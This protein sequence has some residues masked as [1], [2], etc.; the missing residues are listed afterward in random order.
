MKTMMIA[1][2]PWWA[3]RILKGE[4]TV[5]LRKILPSR[6][7]N[8]RWPFKVLLYCTKGGGKF[9]EWEQKVIGEVTCKEI[10]T[11]YGFVK[12]TERTYGINRQLLK[13]SCVSQDALLKYADGRP[14]YGMILEQP[15]EYQRKRELEEYGVKWP[16][17]SYIYVEDY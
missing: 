3:E 10:R 7:S 4:K 2:K 1:I 6:T 16:P 9:P 11:V 12:G 13:K 15:V 14:V 5:E 8:E 17:Q